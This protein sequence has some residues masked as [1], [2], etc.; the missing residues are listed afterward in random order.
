MASRDSGDACFYWRLLGQIVL[1]LAVV[2]H[3]NHQVLLPVKLLVVLLHEVSHGLMALATGGMVEDILIAPN[4]TGACRTTGGSEILIVSAGYLGS[5]FFGGMLLSS[6]RS[7]GPS[8][9]MYTALALLVF[10]AAIT[11]MQDPYSRRFAV[12][13]AGAALLVGV[14]APNWIASL[15]L[16]GVGTVSCLYALIDIYSDTLSDSARAGTLPSDAVAFA[17]ITGVAP[18]AVGLAWLVVS[19]V[20][21]F[22][23]LRASLYTAARRADASAPHP[24]LEHATEA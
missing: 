20:Y 8:V 15:V 19:F 18:D 21:F 2:A 22:L 23:T 11:V 13:V 7:Q 1:I 14:F 17:D 6:S 9:A 12:A 24:G 16:R 3:W 5:M 10:G 4:E